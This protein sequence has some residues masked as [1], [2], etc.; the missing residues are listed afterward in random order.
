MKT[1]INDVPILKKLSLHKMFLQFESQQTTLKGR[2]F[3]E[4]L[5]RVKIEF[6]LSVRKCLTMTTAVPGQQTRYNVNTLNARSFFSRQENISF[7]FPDL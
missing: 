3:Q 7:G 6:P 4:I 1:E 2:M 5:S